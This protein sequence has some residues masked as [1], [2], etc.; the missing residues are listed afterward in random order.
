MH[1]AAGPSVT[2]CESDVRRVGGMPVRYDRKNIAVLQFRLDRSNSRIWN[3]GDRKRGD[4]T[5]DFCHLRNHR[6]IVP[7]VT[8]AANRSTCL[9]V[10]NSSSQWNAA[11]RWR[12]I[13]PKTSSFVVGKN[14]LEVMHTT[15]VG[16]I[17][18]AVAVAFEL[19]VMQERPP[20][21]GGRV[22]FRESGHRERGLIESPAIEP[23][24]V[25]RWRFDPVV[26]LEGVV[27]IGSTTE[28]GSDGSGPLTDRK[29]CPSFAFCSRAELSKFGFALEYG[30]PGQPWGTERGIP[31]VGKRSAMAEEQSGTRP[32]CD[33]ESA[34]A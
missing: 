20:R 12:N 18:T 2:L 13:F 32:S 21:P 15:D 5:F 3:V 34:A 31:S 33:G 8:R 22:V 19:D 1:E 9:H 10:S 29:G 17:A 14:F 30:G 24:K 27:H 28:R 26:D 25:Y 7:Q 6:R 16:A 23:F 4:V 11:E